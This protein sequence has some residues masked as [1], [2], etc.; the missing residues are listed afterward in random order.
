VVDYR[1]GDAAKLVRQIDLGTEMPSSTPAF[2]K[3][4]QRSYLVARLQSTPANVEAATNAAL[5]FNGPPA[6]VQ[7]LVV[8]G[9]VDRAYWLLNDPRAF[10]LVRDNT[11][12]LF[13]SYMR[14]FLFDRRFMPL[15][16]RLG[17]IQFWLSSDLWPAFCYDKDVPYNCKAEARRQHYPRRQSD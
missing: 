4:L 17:L 9:R 16:E 10:A 14:T 3:G 8:L 15:A 12:V 7:N 2:A 5:K 13:R 11:D 6:A 1:Y